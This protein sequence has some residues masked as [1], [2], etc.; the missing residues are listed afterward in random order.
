MAGEGLSDQVTPDRHLESLTGVW[1]RALHRGSV[2]C[3]GPE[4]GMSLVAPGMARRPV[5]LKPVGE[6]RTEGPETVSDHGVRQ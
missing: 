2:R 6:T 1:W 5:W 3:K 4:V